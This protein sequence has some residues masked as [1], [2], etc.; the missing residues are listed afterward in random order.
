MVDLKLRWWA[1]PPLLRLLLLLLLLLVLLPLRLLRL[2][3]RPLPLLFLTPLLPR[4]MTGGGT[5][6]PL[7]LRNRAAK[8]GAVEPGPAGDRER[9]SERA[10]KLG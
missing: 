6:K 2:L 9:A 7:L 5:E 4:K 10:R 1:T 8:S 3:P